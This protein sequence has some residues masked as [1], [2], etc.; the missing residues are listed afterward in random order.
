MGQQRDFRNAMKSL[1]H[2]VCAYS[3]STNVSWPLFT[4]PLFESYA[5]DILK[6]SNLEA[7]AMAPYLRNDQQETWIQYANAPRKKWVEDSHVIRQ[8]NLDRLKPAG[9]NPFITRPSPN[10]FVPDIS[11]RE[12]YFPMWSFSPAPATYGA[13]NWN[14]AAE[15]DFA[16]VI[17]DML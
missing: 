4:L 3:E 1:A 5:E 15:P 8:G 9:Y 6:Q 10:G 14:V 7:I 16:P 2:Q 17:E 12:Y 13:V 11:E